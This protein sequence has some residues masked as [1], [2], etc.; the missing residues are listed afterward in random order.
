MRSLEKTWVEAATGAGRRD[1][2]PNQVAC[3]RAGSWSCR[4]S[5]EG[6]G[7]WSGYLFS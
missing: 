3:S 2:V 6:L 4:S 5:G 1:V 7:G